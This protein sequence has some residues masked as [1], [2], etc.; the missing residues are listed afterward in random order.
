[1]FKNEMKRISLFFICFFLVTGF[2]PADT[3]QERV[4]SKARTLIGTPYSTGGVTPSGFDCS[5]FITYLY[6][7]HVPKLP[8]VSRDMARSGVPVK[9][10]EMLPGDL[11]FFATGSSPGRVT[12]VALYIGQNSIIHSISNGPERGVTV[13]SLNA[14]YWRKRYHNS[15]RIIRIKTKDTSEKKSFAENAVFAKGIYNGPLEE[16][17][18][19][20][21][22]ILLMKN[23]DRYKGDFSKGLFH[24]TGTYIWADGKSYTGNFN[25]G[26]FSGNGNLIMSDGKRIPG[27]WINGDFTPDSDYIVKSENDQEGK[28]AGKSEAASSPDSLVT[29]AAASSAEVK[30]GSAAAGGQSGAEDPARSSDDMTG[31]PVNYMNKEDSPWNTYDGIVEG[32]FSLWF[33]KDM[34]NFEKW[35]KQNQPG[36]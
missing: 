26:E 16:G 32:D 15:S 11:I 24:G 14:G 7:P 21:S 31:F 2:T 36:S 13:S 28:A 10:D 18:P 6:K 5:G 1:M 34:E 22:G 8:R 33:K 29:S 23:G 4:I 20:G 19:S 27:K 3:V 25:R 30:K 9:R 17:E 35:K 12:H